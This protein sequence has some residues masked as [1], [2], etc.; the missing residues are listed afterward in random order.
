[1]YGDFAFFKNLRDNVLRV[2]VVFFSFIG[3][4]WD[5]ERIIFRLF[6]VDVIWYFDFVGVRGGVYLY[7][8]G[9]LLWVFFEKRRF[10][11]SCLRYL[12]FYV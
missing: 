12:A 3:K 10:R 6:F 4:S 11:F 7:S 2:A 8:S 5:G 9:F 1:M